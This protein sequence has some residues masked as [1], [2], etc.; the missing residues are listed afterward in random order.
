MPISRAKDCN[1]LVINAVTSGESD[2]SNCTVARFGSVND[3]PSSFSERGQGSRFKSIFL[4]L[5][6]CAFDNS[7]FDFGQ[8][9]ETID[10]LVDEGVG[11]IDLRVER[12][13]FAFGFLK[14]VADF[15]LV[16]FPDPD[17]VGVQMGEQIGGF[18]FP[19]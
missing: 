7:D 19:K 17:S 10:D 5:T 11:E 2:L 14:T 13:E 3:P 15:F 4:C 1:R 9:V 18:Q 8:T 16:R 6:C 12:N